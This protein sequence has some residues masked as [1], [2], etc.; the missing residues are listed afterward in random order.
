MRF[1]I[2][3]LALWIAPS[4]FAVEPEPRTDGP[5]QLIRTVDTPTDQ[6][7][8][9]MSA[10]VRESQLGYVRYSAT[11]RKDVVDRFLAHARENPIKRLLVTNTCVYCADIF[12]RKHAATFDDHSIPEHGRISLLNYLET[13]KSAG[14]Q[15]PLM[16]RAAYALLAAYAHAADW[17]R[18]RRAIAVYKHA[19]P[20]LDEQQRAYLTFVDTIASFLEDEPAVGSDDV[21]ETA[22]FGQLSDVAEDAYE[23]AYVAETIETF[24]ALKAFAQEALMWRRVLADYFQMRGW[25]AP[26]LKPIKER[27]WAKKEHHSPNDG[28]PFCAGAQFTAAPFPSFEPLHWTYAAYVEVQFETDEDGRV[29]DATILRAI[30]SEINDAGTLE[31]VLNGEMT[32]DDPGEATC[33]KNRTNIVQPFFLHSKP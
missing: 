26:D 11:L 20:D 27:S 33:R 7:N 29:A 32:F 19:S 4:A 3:C 30:P 25:A 13:A 14:Y 5:Q 22:F 15:S 31:A 24:E 6:Q 17:D 9:D 12:F 10:F 2:L 18:F 21:P 8:A 1:S 16:S 28:L 23:R